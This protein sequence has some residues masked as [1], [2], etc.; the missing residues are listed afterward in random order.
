MT[1]FISGGRG[2]GKTYMQVEEMLKPGNEQSM[3]VAATTARALRAHEMALAILDERGEQVGHD[4][5]KSLQDRFVG[6]LQFDGRQRGRYASRKVYVDDVE[7][8]L[9]VLLST[10]IVGMTTSVPVHTITIKTDQE[11]ES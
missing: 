3:Y 9:T 11:N 7:D 5:R 6:V 2:V 8:V 1:D 4:R 10:E